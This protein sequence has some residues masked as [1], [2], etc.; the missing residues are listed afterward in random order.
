MVHAVVLGIHIAAGALGLFLGPVAMWRGS[1]RLAEGQSMR[2]GADT[3][4]QWSVLTVCLS[5]IV[6]VIWFR[7]EL[8]WLVPVAAFSYSLVLLG[9]VAAATRFRGW[10]HAYAHGQG[11]SYIAV[12]TALV[13]VASTVDGPVHGPAEAIPWALPVVVGTLL[14]ELWRR[15]LDAHARAKPGPTASHRTE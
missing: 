3:A 4:Y 1:R 9:H 12:V 5:A 14:I 15:S 2:S 8:W 6:L 7:P 11:G 13:V 10:T